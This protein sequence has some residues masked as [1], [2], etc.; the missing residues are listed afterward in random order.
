MVTL[1][2]NMDSSTKDPKCQSAATAAKLHKCHL[3]PSAGSGASPEC[4]TPGPAESCM[5]HMELASQ[6]TSLGALRSIANS[7]KKEKGI[8]QSDL[9]RSE[10]QCNFCHI[11]KILLAWPPGL[12]NLHITLLASPSDASPSSRYLCSSFRQEL[13]WGSSLACEMQEVR[14]DDHNSPFHP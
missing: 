2:E 6:N 10:H 11:L 4:L 13:F 14:P 12:Y 3:H 5:S 9:N 7:Y 8:L 1:D